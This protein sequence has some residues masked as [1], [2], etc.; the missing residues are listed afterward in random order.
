MSRTHTTGTSHYGNAGASRPQATTDNLIQPMPDFMK[1]EPEISPGSN[2]VAAER[3]FQWRILGPDGTTADVF[4]FPQTTQ[5]QVG[6]C[7]LGT[8]VEPV[9]QTMQPGECES[10]MFIRLV[11]ACEAKPTASDSSTH[12]GE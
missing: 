3:H 1:H 8:T 5:R 7:Y 10:E 9:P 11:R 6:A 2:N 12:R 4:F